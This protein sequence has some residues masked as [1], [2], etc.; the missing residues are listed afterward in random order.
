MSRFPELVMR[1]KAKG[2]H[3]TAYYPL[4]AFE[5][6]DL[7]DY[8]GPVMVWDIDKTYLSTRLSSTWGM[9]RIPIEAAV[10][11]MPVPGMPQVLRGLRKG[12]G[13]GVACTPLY[14]VSASP[15]CLKRTLERRM[16]MDGVE[17]DGITFKDWSRTLTSFTPYRLF[18]QQGYKF[19]ALLEG[20]T[21]RPLSVE[22]LFG[23]DFEMDSPAYY[24]YS[25]IINNRLSQDEAA[26]VMKEEGI[27]KHDLRYALDLLKRM[28]AQTG[29]V[30]RIFIHLE[31]G[32]MPEEFNC[33]GNMLIP[34]RGAYQLALAL[35][36]L[37]LV[38]SDLVR[39]TA[40]EVRRSGSMED[41]ESERRDAIDRGL[42]TLSKAPPPGPSRGVD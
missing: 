28:P 1:R 12:P 19:C 41:L 13:A 18:D 34:V 3:R 33:Y 40:E 32:T 42:I 20:R 26:G 8:R 16:L 24:L 30:E 14:F 11:K 5:T 38:D 39:R 21:R 31:Q 37:D 25:R 23:D 2:M 7:S 36:Q 6:R 29:R 17:Q 22:Y 9:A 10:D 35:L 15:P 4:K 27:R